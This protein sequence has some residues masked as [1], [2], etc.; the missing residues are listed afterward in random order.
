MGKSKAPAPPDPKE[1][2]G[3]QTANN[4]G[5]AI[6]NA[7]LG[8][9]NQTTPLGSL[10][11]DQTGSYQY[12]DPN[13]GNVYDIPTFTANTSLTEDGQRIQDANTG[14]SINMAELARDQSGRIG[15]LLSSPMDTSGLPARGSASNINTK[16]RAF[17]GPMA[18][19]TTSIADAGNIQRGFADAGDITKSYGTDF[20]EDRQ[21]VEDALMSRLNPSLER[22]QEALRTS[23]INQGVREGSTAYDRAMSRFGE[24]SNDARMQA[25][26]AGG[27][28][29]SRMVGMEADRAQF[30]NAA[31]GQN[32]NQLLGR[33]QFGNAAQSQ[34]F[35]QN[36]TESQFYN[37]GT[38]QNNQ[39]EM[40]RVGFNNDV[41]GQN[42][43]EQMALEGRKDADRSGAF[44]EMMAMRNQPI[45][46]IG[47]L[48][49]TGQVQQPNFVNTSMPSIPTVD[50]AGLE[51]DNYNQRLNIWQQQQAQSQSLM[52]GLL[53]LG[54]NLGSAMIMGSDR[55]LKRDIEP[56]GTYGRLPVYRYK[57]NDSDAVRVGFMA[58]EVMAVDPSAIVFM[59]GGMMAVDYGK[60]MEAA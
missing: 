15:Q 14:A 20:S 33:G 11:Y 60:A 44:Q 8:N 36:A 38:N 29:Q 12:T 21:R 42:F 37:Q 30:Q 54:G 34:Q 32:Y 49:G 7:H 31:Q 26:L 2:A 27:E 51:M 5:T 52:G 40:A 25:I 45:N 4:I 1:T 23:L 41:I 59:D 3:A 9:V 53:G 16:E 28:E 46:E 35:G 18:Q 57:Y 55:R 24:Q 56:I 43:A 17:L 50:R 48:L 47:A 6:A 58:D 10:S 39:A 19:A 13:N 22:D